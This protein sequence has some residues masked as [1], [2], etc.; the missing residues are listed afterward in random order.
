MAPFV[1]SLRVAAPGE[2]LADRKEALRY[3]GYGKH[4]PDDAVLSLLD[5]CEKELLAACQGRACWVRVPVLF[6]AEFTVDLGF[7]PVESVSLSKHLAGCHSALLFAA[8]IGI[9][10]DRLIARWN[11]LS[12][13]R[14]AVVDALGSS[15]IERWC[16]TV[17]LELTREEEKHCDRF[18]PGYGDFA[19]RHQKD[20]MSCLDMTRLL[21]VTLSDS[22]LM[23]PVKSVT[24]V[25]GLGASARTCGNKC[26]FCTK[27]NCIYREVIV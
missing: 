25:I 16:D 18:S 15:V 23:K 2:L 27:E 20:F 11:R 10:A 6:P 22:L 9:G 21:G 5:S 3:L 17:E 12:P 1:P 8:T 24:A 26:M 19:L 14:S 13:S 7:G 4:Q